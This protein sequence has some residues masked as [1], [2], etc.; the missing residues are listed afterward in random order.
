M[1]QE[2]SLRHP[3]GEPNQGGGSGCTDEK[4]KKGEGNSLT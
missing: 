4:I 3:A 2:L 1:S